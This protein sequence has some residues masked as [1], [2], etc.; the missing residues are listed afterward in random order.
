MKGL[1]FTYALT[2]GGAVVS[3]FNPYVGLLIYI[4][5][6]IIKPEAMWFWS[7]PE[8]NYSRIV[9]IALL[10]GWALKGFGSWRFGRAR[11]V[12][13]ALLGF[14]GWSALSA[15]S[16]PGQTEAWASVEALTKVVLPFLVGITTIDSVRK[17]K[18]LAWVILLSLGYVA[19][20]LNL[21][22]YS[23]FNRVV[24]MDFA[25]MDNNCVAIAM[26]TGVGLAF[27]LGLYAESWWRRALALVAA[28]LMAHVVM[29]AFS[30][31]GVLA[32]IITCFAAF[33]LI[34]KQ[35]KH[36]LAFVAAILLG[37]R[38][39]G[40]EVRERFVTVFA[41]AKQRDESAQSRLDLW[42]DC[43]DTLLNKPL[44]GA[45][46]HNWPLL[47]PTYGWPLGKEAHTLW[48]QT[49]AEVGVPG[50][51]CLLSFYGL[52]VVRLWP[53]TRTG[54]PVA[55]P[56]YR[57]S[58]RMVIASLVGF[59]V[60]AQFVSLEELE[61]PYYIVLIGAGT[62][63]LSSLAEPAAEGAGYAPDAAQAHGWPTVGG[64]V[65]PEQPLRGQ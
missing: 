10:A 62:L 60:S 57:D 49:A 30:R 28:G 15:A 26:V 58:A 27:F 37:I 21:S 46:P 40:P 16:A 8:G 51:V 59:A 13:F 9:A 24:E 53:L 18:Q 33:L 41:D 65:M 17:L 44:L 25:L 38:L 12:V 39:A 3:L 50:I 61:L 55:D 19:Y 20:E 5:F 42:K 1:L 56:W 32:L 45:G 7:V 54:R 11:A 63:K 48:L 52:C 31:G 29:F 43:W 36:Y 2:Y 23:G 6:S 14:W 22:Y 34:E 35:P 4:C 64:W 47:A